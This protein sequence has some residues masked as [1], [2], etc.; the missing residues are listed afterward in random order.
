MSVEPSDSISEVWTRWQGH[1]VNGAFPLGRCLGSSDH[2]GVFL[3]RA[4]ARGLAEVAIKLIPANRA[5]AELQ[6]PRWKRAG[7]LAHPHLLR[8][9]EWGGCQLDGLPYLYAVMEY[10]DQTLAQLLLQRALTEDEAREM[11]LPTLNALAFLH[12]QDLVQGALKPANILVVGDQLKLATDTIRRAGDG[13]RSTDTLTAYDPPEARQGRS[14][15]ATDI[16][17]LGLSLFEALTRRLPSGLGEPGDAVVLPPDF[18]PAFREVVSGCLSP[19]PQDRPSLTEL[20]AWSQGRAAGSGSAATIQP[21][22]LVVPETRTPEP[23]PPQSAPP[24]V[25]PDPAAPAPS[26]AVSLKA[27]AWPA[28]M[29]GAVVLLALAWIVIRMLSTSPAPPP[30]R[31]QAP[32]GSAS[33]IAGVAAPV[34][35]DSAT[36]PGPGGVST[37]PAALHQV[38]PDIPWSARRTIRGHIKVWVRVVIGQDG[39]VFA[40]VADR[41]GPSRYFQRVAL[42]AAR[43]WT[44]P[45]VDTPPRR[46]MQIQFD[47]SRD[48][49]TGRAVTLH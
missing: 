48:G 49:T 42:E 2:S 11:L 36:K 38:I 8:L 40:A 3:T 18:S 35:A 37:S 24:Q 26:M 23:A 16:W 30:P 31:V 15:P 10:A 29:L 5:L 19:N 20:A 17:A 4:A 34:T 14:S 6:L 44:F 39:S 47:F 45:P 9:L 7:A 22:A 43:R 33:Q 25:A 28:V 13:T 12:G 1:V 27:R 21:A 46:L 41:S 32:G